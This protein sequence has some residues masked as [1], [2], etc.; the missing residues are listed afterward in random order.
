MVPARSWPDSALWRA[1]GTCSST[2]RILLAEKKGSRTSPVRCR[3]SSSSPW[4]RS[5]RHAAAPRMHC[6]TIAA[7]TGR[8]ELRSQTTAGLALVGDGQA[9]ERAHVHRA[10]DQFSDYREDV[11]VDLLRIV[12]GPVRPRVMLPVGPRCPRQNRALFIEDHALRGRGALV[13][14]QDVHAGSGEQQV[15]D[16][17]LRRQRILPALGGG[18]R[19]AVDTVDQRVQLPDGANALARRYPRGPSRKGN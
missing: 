15:Q 13:H 2:H 18:E 8:P 9:G 3:N 1:P 6:Q 11:A 14:G 12:L 19:F 10:P 5:S 16:Q 7:C 17:A 4:S